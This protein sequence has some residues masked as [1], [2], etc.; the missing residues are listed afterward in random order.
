MTDRLRQVLEDN[1]PYYLE[2]LMDLVCIDTHDI[3]HGID[4]GLEKKG[5]EYLKA[6]LAEMGADTI[7]EHPVTEDLIQQSVELY[8]EGNPGH[9]YEDRANLYATFKGRGGKSILFNG[10]M[11]TMPAVKELWDHDPHEPHLENGRLHG[12]GVCDMKSGLMASV[13]AVKLIRDAGL[14]LPGDVLITSVIDEEGGGNGSIAAVMN[15]IRADAAV[16]CEPTDYELI[17]A[18]MGFVFFKVEVDGIAVHSGTKWNG[19]NAIEKAVKLMDAI[20]ELEHNWLLTYKHPLLPAPNSNV[21]VIQG[22]TAGSTVPDKCVFKT[23]VHYLP[24]V[25]THDQVVQEYTDAILTRCQGDAWLKD[26]LPRISIYQAGGPFEM[27]LDHPFVETFKEAF[28]T[29]KSK[30]VPVVGSPSGCDSRLWRNI[31][32]MPTLQYGPG[33]LAQCHAVDEYIDIE[34]YYDAIAIYAELILGW[35]S[36]QDHAGTEI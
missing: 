6:L 21:G 24:E 32:Q 25:M 31:A 16:V 10:H 28:Q 13:M 1:K 3:G 29:V 27:E 15:G 5:Q 30:E 35:G 18:H 2:K 22:G 8:K 12:L 19:V 34:Q 33:T 11:D 17:A 14:E 26:H 23:C 36:R 4:G 9:N 7:E 20:G